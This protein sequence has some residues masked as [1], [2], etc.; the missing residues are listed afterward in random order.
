MRKFN[1]Y[2]VDIKTGE[3]FWVSHGILQILLS[4]YMV[5]FDINKKMYYFN[6]NRRKEVLQLIAY[7]N[8]C[9]E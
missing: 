5:N 7:E 6:H 2:I 4:Y 9:V 8:I 3:V 1:E